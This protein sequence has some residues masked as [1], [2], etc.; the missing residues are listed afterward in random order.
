MFIFPTLSGTHAQSHTTTKHTLRWHYN[1]VPSTATGPATH[2][3]APESFVRVSARHKKKVQS[4]AL[5]P[6]SSSSSFTANTARLFGRSGFCCAH[7]DDSRPRVHSYEFIR[8]PVRQPLHGW[9]M[10][11]QYFFLESACVLCASTLPPHSRLNSSF[12]NNFPSK[13]AFPDVWT[14]TVGQFTSA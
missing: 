13:H 12:L 4:H 10:R 11:A 6:C 1:C 14:T 2:P 9:S 3:R 7:S 8:T 5:V